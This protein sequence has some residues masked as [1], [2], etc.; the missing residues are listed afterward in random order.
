M[1]NTILL[2]LLSCTLS[3]LGK[4]KTDTVYYKYIYYQRCFLRDKEKG[5]T[6]RKYNVHSLSISGGKYS[7]N[8]TPITKEKY[9]K[10]DSFERNVCDTLYAKLPGKYC[11]LY[12]GDT[13]MRIEGRW[14]VEFW[15]GSYKEYY[16]NG[17][18]KIKGFYYDG[19]ENDKWGN[20]ERTWYFYNRRGKLKKV[21]DYDKK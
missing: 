19:E 18:L 2:L 14:C 11:K 6:L 3:G 9:E 10:L 17:I 8:G 12:I 15:K 1:K 13:I 21:I 5:P 7:L 4:S 20:K 16:N